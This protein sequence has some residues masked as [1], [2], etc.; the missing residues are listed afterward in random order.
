MTW[1]SHYGTETE[2]GFEPATFASN[3][4]RLTHSTTAALFSFSSQ[5]SQYKNSLCV[6]NLFV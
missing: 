4:A 3:A 6:K 5:S 1:G 2:V